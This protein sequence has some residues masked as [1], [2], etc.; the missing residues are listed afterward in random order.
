M[1]D[2]PGQRACLSL[3]IEKA[4]VVATGE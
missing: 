1:A 3:M 4:G 2:S